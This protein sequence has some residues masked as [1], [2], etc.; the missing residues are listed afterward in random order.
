MTTLQSDLFT[1]LTKLLNDNSL[2]TVNPG[3]IINVCVLAIQVVDQYVSGTGEE[4]KNACKM[5]IEKVTGTLDIHDPELVNNFLSQSLNK[6]I[7]VIIDVSRGNYK[8][9]VKE[10][11]TKC[12]SLGQK[13]KMAFICK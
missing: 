3:N 6:F 13:I 5:L 9:N 12:K 11:T 10:Q 4:K 8:I 2:T 1:H 7:D